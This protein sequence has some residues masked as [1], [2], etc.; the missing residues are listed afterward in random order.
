MYKN[1]DELVAEG[2]K[3]MVTVKP[4]EEL[5]KDNVEENVEDK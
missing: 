2:E 3:E 4:E 5:K 1:F